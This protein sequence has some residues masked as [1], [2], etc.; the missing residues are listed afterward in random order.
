MAPFS[1]GPRVP[2]SQDYPVRPRAR[3]GCK[4]LQWKA[5]FLLTAL[6]AAMVPVAGAEDEL[7]TA[8][9]CVSAKDGAAVA[10][11]VASNTYYQKLYPN[12]GYYIEEIWQE[13]NG[14][15]GLQTSAGMSCNGK[16]DKMLSRACM[17]FCPLTV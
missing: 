1:P 16:A 8:W 3:L 7:D 5:T 4:P 2:T 12:G 9:I 14:Q 15:P 10:F 17:G 6:L 11:A 13:S